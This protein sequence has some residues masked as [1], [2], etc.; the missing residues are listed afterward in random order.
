MN[1]RVVFLLGSVG[2]G[3][4][5]VA[6]VVLAQNGVRTPANPTVS[7]KVAIAREKEAAEQAL[8]SFV[9]SPPPPAPLNSQPQEVSESLS[10]TV[11]ADAEWSDLK[12]T[13]TDVSHLFSTLVRGSIK[14]ENLFRNAQ[15]NEHDAYIHPA[16]RAYIA[17]RVDAFEQLKSAIA[18]YRLAAG[19][20]EMDA[21]MEK[22][23]AR[24][25][26]LPAEMLA[27]P[28]YFPPAFFDGP[29]PPELRIQGV[30][31]HYAYFD[32][33]PETRN[34][35]EYYEFAMIQF[36]EELE[37]VMIA[38]GGSSPEAAAA[39]REACIA[40]FRQQIQAWSGF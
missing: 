6:T 15:L 28:G 18:N 11:S 40:K 16:I 10:A 19:K 36:L 5:L 25:S 27:S 1:K 12:R 21:L 20:N 37:A 38:V 2:A 17:S 7:G 32:Q 26:K 4:L 35:Y 30:T 13:E 3:A 29:H 8:A 34:S 31:V 9:D 39:M 24:S 22:G 14:P 23:E 33:L